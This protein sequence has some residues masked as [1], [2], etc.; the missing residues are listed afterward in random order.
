MA[1]HVNLDL[2]LVKRK[3]TL[4]KLADRVG[5]TIANAVTGPT[6]L[7]R[8]SNGVTEDRTLTEYAVRW[9]ISRDR[10]VTQIIDS[11]EATE[12]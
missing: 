5:I 11:V 8:D 2:M 1:I 3:I 6:R 4:T 12:V 7:S 10:A 9:I